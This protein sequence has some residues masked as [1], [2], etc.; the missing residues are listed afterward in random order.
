MK[1]KVLNLERWMVY[2]NTREDCVQYGSHYYEIPPIL[3]RDGYY[4]YG[5]DCWFEVNGQAWLCS[6]INAFEFTLNT[7]H[8]AEY[9]PEQIIGLSAI[10]KTNLATKKQRSMM[11]HY[12]DYVDLISSRRTQKMLF[13][14][15]QLMKDSYL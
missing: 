15:I 3:N 12:E 8:A 5:N 10:V 7:L 1:L 6:D 14:K 9:R 11:R 13:R 2:D 4:K